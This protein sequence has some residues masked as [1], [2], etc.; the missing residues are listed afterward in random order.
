MKETIFHSFTASDYQAVCTFFI[1]LNRQDK[2]HINWNWARWEWM[3][4]HA[5]FDRSRM[6]TIG[7]WKSGGQ[8]AGAAIYDL[9]YGEAFC[10]ALDSH[11]ELLPEIIAYAVRNFQ[12]ENGLGIAVNDCDEDMK[13]LLGPMGFQIADQQETVLRLSLDKE[14]PYPLPS[15]VILREIC[16]PQDLLAYKTVI[17]KGF[18]HEGDTQEWE[19]MLKSPRLPVHLDPFLCLAAADENDHFLAHCS[20]WYDRETDYA[21]I[22]PVCT[23]P[24][25]RK[26][27]LG[28]AVLL[29][30]LNRCRSLGAKE[31]FVISEQE[32]YKRLGFTPY[33]HYHFY[34]LHP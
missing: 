31:A 10:G 12:D 20:C 18:D 2:T 33:A 25:D 23:V 15:G 19:K 21:Y 24:A 6:N 28:R 30:A 8:I 29:E 13:K 17:W 34:W 32:F 14:L 7:L 3:Y 4:H 9:Y 5:Y 26:K 27:G 16:F 22:E 1:E 11:R